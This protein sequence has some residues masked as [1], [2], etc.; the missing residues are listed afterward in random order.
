MA[1]MSGR[2][3][4]MAEWR[5]KPATLTPKLVEPGSTVLPCMSTLTREEAVTSWYSIPKGFSRKCSV[6][7]L[8]RAYGRGGLDVRGMESEC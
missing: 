4:W 5:V 1:L 6:S 8:T 7:W 3:A 2:A